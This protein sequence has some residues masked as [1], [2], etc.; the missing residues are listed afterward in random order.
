MVLP[1]PALDGERI[2]APLSRVKLPLSRLLDA[3][4]PGQLLCAGMLKPPLVGEAQ[5][6]SLLLADY[7]AREELAVANADPSS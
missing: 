7:F 1:L 3:L 4:T 5:A 2:N 6:R